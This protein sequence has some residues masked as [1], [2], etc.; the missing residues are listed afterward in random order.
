VN[1]RSDSSFEILSLQP[2]GI[3]L[4]PLQVSGQ[5]VSARLNRVF[6]SGTFHDLADIDP[7]QSMEESP[8]EMLRRRLLFFR[9]WTALAGNQA[10]PRKM[11]CLRMK[12]AR[13]EAQKQL[14]ERLA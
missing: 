6:A 11:S 4:L 2:K 8:E 13:L 7:S 10:F 12:G 1:S 14:P 3:P 5:F 9:C